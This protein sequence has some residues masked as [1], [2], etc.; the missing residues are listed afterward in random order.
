MSAEQLGSALTAKARTVIAQHAEAGARL[1]EEFFRNEAETLITV[2]LRIAAALASGRKILLCGNGGSAADAQHLAGEFVNRFLMDR[3]PLA[4][5]ALSTDTS[6]LTA[7]G[8]DFGFEQVF[9][10]QVQAIGNVGDVLLSLSASGN[11]ENVV[12][13]MQAGR[14]QGLLTVS[15]TGRGGGTMAGLSDFLL[16]VPSAHTP[17]I[18]E[19][20]IAAGHVLCQLTDYFLFENVAALAPFLSGQG[21]SQSL[22]DVE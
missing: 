15:L 4:A 9:Q 2:A 19:T 11:S 12:C 16:A 18:Q 3:P 21:L 22:A 17:L 13:A 10:K 8:N 1:R 5:V 14:E 20:H 7:I 6:V